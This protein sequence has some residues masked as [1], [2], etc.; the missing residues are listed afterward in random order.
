MEKLIN[1]IK[2]YNNNKSLFIALR[3]YIFRYLIDNENTKD[4][5]NRNLISELGNAEL[6][7]LKT[8][9]IDELKNNLNIQFGELDLKVEVIIRFY[10]E[11]CEHI[12][13]EEI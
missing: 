8:I 7:D 12:K 11:L 4:I 10:S 3:R 13:I 2:N 9:K 5:E 1:K 6:W